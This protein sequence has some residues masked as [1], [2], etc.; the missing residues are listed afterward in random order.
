MVRMRKSGR[1]IEHRRRQGAYQVFCKTKRALAKLFLF[2]E[3]L[4]FGNGTAGRDD[5]IGRG[6]VGGGNVVLGG[7]FTTK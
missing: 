4:C 3:R 5:D 7:V 1:R 2:F 6:G